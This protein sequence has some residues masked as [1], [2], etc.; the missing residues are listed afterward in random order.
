M[1]FGYARVSSLDQNLDSQIEALRKENCDKIIHE[2]VSG[3]SNNKNELNNLLAKLI[4]GDTLIV[5]RMD[6]LGRNT[7]QLLE[8]VELLEKRKIFLN[9]LDLGIDTRKPTGKLI[10][11]IMSAFSEL[12]RTM[13][14]EKQQLGI[15]I[16][17]RKGVYKGRKKKFNKD[18]VGLKHALD[19]RESTNKTVNEICAI[20]GISR[21]T[22]YREKNNQ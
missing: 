21:A 4:S 16:A 20:T 9:I 18:H 13:I 2:K 1:I 12:D 6:R 11:T 7:K 5:T 14:K 15:S 17:K 3:I 10:L 19:L 22:F 8:L